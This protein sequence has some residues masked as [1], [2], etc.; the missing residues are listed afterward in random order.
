MSG[1]M[2]LTGFPGPPVRFIVS[3]VDY[4]TALHAA[5]GAMAALYHRARTGRGQLIDVSLMATAVA[6]M[7]PLIAERAVTGTRR[8]QRGNTA[9]YAAPSDIY[10]TRDG[11]I[12]VPTIG[13][14]M[15][16]S[17]A[18]LVGREDLLDDPRCKD[19]I[20][21][22]D[23]AELINEVMSAWCAARTRDEAIAE[24]ERAR[25][26]CGPVYDLDETMADQQVRARK[27]LEGVDYPGSQSKIPLASPPARLS[28]TAARIR[29]RAP[30][31]GE[32][33]DEVLAEIGFSADEIAAL[34]GEGVI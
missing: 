1:A 13:K 6:F 28:E 19:D 24:L 20:T 34:R 16:R 30:T 9:F 27:L 23:N 33:N 18:R 31:L 14:R 25:V 4:G 12:I 17:W 8:E 5:F 3:W 21:R 15:F 2:S 7:E 11:W 32:H 26:P 22:A 10:K 29:R